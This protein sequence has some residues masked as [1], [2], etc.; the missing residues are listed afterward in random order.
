MYDE[1]DAQRLL[2]DALDIIDHVMAL[3]KIP[4]RIDLHVYGSEYLPG[5]VVVHHEIMDAEDAGLFF[6]RFG[7]GLHQIIVRSF[8]QQRADGV[9]NELYA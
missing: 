4:V 5:S 9:T 6:Y 7:D 8:S 2:D 3:H 1:F